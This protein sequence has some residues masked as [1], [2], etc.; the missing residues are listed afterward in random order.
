[1]PPDRRAVVHGNLEAV[2]TE[3]LDA[4]RM[5]VVRPGA[6]ATTQ[7]LRYQFT[8]ARQTISTN[9]STLAGHSAMPS[10]TTW[11]RWR[12][13]HAAPIPPGLEARVYD[14]LW[15]LGRQ[16]RWESSPPSMAGR[17]RSPR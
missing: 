12:S 14:P 7:L 15:T 11:T 13:A 17:R 4:A 6:Q 9:F 1:V 5:R 8:S 10:V 3:T 16:W 2:L